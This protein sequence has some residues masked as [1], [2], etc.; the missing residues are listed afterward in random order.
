MHS[1]LLDFKLSYSISRVWKMALNWQYLTF[2]FQ[3][4]NRK[5]LNA[6]WNRKRENYFI[7]LTTAVPTCT[8]ISIGLRKSNENFS[9]FCHLHVQQLRKQQRIFVATTIIGSIKVILNA[10]SSGSNTISINTDMSGI[11]TRSVTATFNM[12]LL[13][14]ELLLL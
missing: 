1:F 3:I 12:N 13:L 7:S 6:N 2:P 4:P 14:L 5:Y 8:K 10:T 9:I 11:N